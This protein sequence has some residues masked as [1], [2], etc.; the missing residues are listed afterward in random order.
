MRSVTSSHRRLHARSAAPSPLQPVARLVD[1]LG[2]DEPGHLLVHVLDAPGPD[3]AIGT[4]PLD[5]SVH[6]FTELAGVTAP[7]AWHTFGVRVR[8]RAHH[9]DEP[10]GTPEPVSTT[11]LVDRAGH[12]ASVLRRGGTSLDLPG[13]AEGTIPDLCRRV[14]GL[15]T[16]PPPTPTSRSLWITLWLDRIMAAWNDP[17]RRREVTASWAQLAGLHP[18]VAASPTDDLLRIGDPS[19]L[20][21]LA[22]AH[23]E[24]WPWARLRAEPAAV[25]LPDGPLPVEVTSWMDDGFFARWALGSLAPVETLVTDLLS[26]LDDPL[27]EQLRAC[28]IALLQP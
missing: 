9:L 17:E 20:L 12:E 1:E 24:A 4:A 23:T 28:L 13:R 8:G 15:P 18:A 7:E 3:L 27:R 10:E 25:A 2:E 22:R 14:L 26:L 11:F 21:V 5:R 6:P 16:P 19:R